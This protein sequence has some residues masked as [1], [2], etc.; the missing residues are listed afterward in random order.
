MHNIKTMGVIHLRDE[1]IHPSQIV[2]TSANPYSEEPVTDIVPVQYSG[3]LNCS[4]EC[5]HDFCPVLYY[6]TYLQKKSCET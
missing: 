2:S 3:E 5:I 1:L 6:T 4:E